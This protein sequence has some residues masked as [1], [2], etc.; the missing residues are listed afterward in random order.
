MKRFLLTLI[1][2]AGF[3]LAQV[4]DKTDE[5]VLPQLKESVNLF[6][7]TAFTPNDDGVN[8]QFMVNASGFSSYQLVIF[9]RWGTEIAAFDNYP[10]SWDGNKDGRKVATGVYVFTFSGVTAQ[11]DVLRRSGTITLLR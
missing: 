4:T 1:L 2:L 5:T 10:L 9:D 3:A 6:I 11:G 8:D 7:P